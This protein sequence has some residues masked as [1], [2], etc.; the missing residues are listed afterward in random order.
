MY[1]VPRV[2]A[3]F[4]S[5][6]MDGFGKLTGIQKLLVERALATKEANY[7]YDGTIKHTL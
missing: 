7:D 4:K 5:L 1:A 6:I 3:L 2:L